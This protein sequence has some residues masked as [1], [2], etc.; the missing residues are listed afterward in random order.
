MYYLE[1]TRP[2]TFALLYDKIKDENTGCM[3]PYNSQGRLCG[4]FCPLF[5]LNPQFTYVTLN[6]SIRK[7]FIEKGNVIRLK[8]SKNV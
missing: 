8:E 5:E 4:N 6:C 1:E 7:I 2:G 3:C